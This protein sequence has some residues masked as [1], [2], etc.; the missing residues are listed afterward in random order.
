MTVPAGPTASRSGGSARPVPQPD[1]D[2]HAAAPDAR[3]GDRRAVRGQVVAELGVPGRGPAGEE[4]AGLCQVPRAAPR[5]RRG[6]PPDHRPADVVQVDNDVCALL[7]LT[8]AT[9]VAFFPG[10]A[11]FAVDRG[12][13]AA[14]RG[15][16][17]DSDVPAPARIQRHLDGARVLLPG[18]LL[19]EPGR[20]ELRL[21]GRAVDQHAPGRGGQELGQAAKH[22]LPPAPAAV[23]R[24][25][26]RA[27]LSGGSS[28]GG[29][30]PIMQTPLAVRKEY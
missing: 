27:G 7:V 8:P 14:R 9:F 10:L 11:V 20:E 13:P 25:L 5:E 18:Q 12:M 4:R 29:H 1:V 21:F 30:D 3:L 2:D 19:R 24:R 23:D 16:Q 22:L 17:E 26:P 28:D 6:H 15:P